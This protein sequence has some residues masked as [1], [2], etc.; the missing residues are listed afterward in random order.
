MLSAMPLMSLSPEPIRSS[1]LFMALTVVSLL[2]AKLEQR[3]K[4]FAFLLHGGQPGFQL[5]LGVQQI[6]ELD[7]LAFYLFQ[8]GRHQSLGAVE[9]ALDCGSG[10]LVAFHQEGVD[11]T[12]LLVG[13]LL[14]F[15][16][17]ALDR[18]YFAAHSRSGVFQI[19]QI[20]FDLSDVL[21]DDRHAVGLERLIDH[22][23]QVGGDQS[24]DFFH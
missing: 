21:V 19:F 16:Q 24:R 9:P 14:E 15:A 11:G 12:I 3:L 5:D 10:R 13:L 6:A 8:I 18:A 17:L 7:A 1:R 23:V 22:V 20:V 2:L 4:F